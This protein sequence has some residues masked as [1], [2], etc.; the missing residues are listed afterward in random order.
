MANDLGWG[1]GISIVAISL[2]IKALFGPLMFSSQLNTIKMKLIEPETKNFNASLQKLTQAKDMAGSR[3]LQKQYVELRQRYGI[4]MLTPFIS[5]LQ[6][7]ILMTWFFSLRYVCS[8]PEQYPG[9]VSQG[10][11]WFKDLSEY[12]PYGVLPVLSSTMTYLNISM[13]PNM[14]AG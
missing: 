2:G 6:V 7:P 13:N 4:S 9:L 14:A 10:F 5:M 1:M 3:A 8:L 11:L 12:D